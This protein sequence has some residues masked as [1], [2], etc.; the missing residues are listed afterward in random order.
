VPA[1]KPQPPP[2]AP[3]DPDQAALEIALWESIKDTNNQRLFEAFLQ[4]Y[5][6]GAFSQA[7]RA[8][9][10]E[11]KAAARASVGGPDDKRV[12]RDPT[13]LRNSASGCMEST[14]TPVRWTAPSASRR[15]AQS[16][17]SKPPIS[18]R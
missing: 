6:T 18:W 10:E 11:L 13:L 1:P 5:P 9:L 12:I 16:A 14:S 2:V 8:R 4:R 15:A 17:S 3:R 7:A